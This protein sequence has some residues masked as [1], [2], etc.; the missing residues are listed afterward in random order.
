M[1]IHGPWTYLPG[2]P[3]T[4]KKEHAHIPPI[5]RPA[6]D[7]LPQLVEVEFLTSGTSRDR[8]RRGVGTWKRGTTRATSPGSMAT[9][10]KWTGDRA[11][12]KP[13]FQRPV[14][15]CWYMHRTH[16]SFGS[17][18]CG[19]SRLS[20]FRHVL[21][22]I[23]SSV[24]VGVLRLAVVMAEDLR[25]IRRSLLEGLNLTCSMILDDWVAWMILNVLIPPFRK[26]QL[27]PQSDPD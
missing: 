13:P 24:K 6:A 20:Q 16:I 14:G 22:A 19:K 18:V 1:I 8:F 25:S 17:A 27:V 23:F 3:W 15:R 26:R 4:R 12:P 2:R 9:S 11:L 10:N 21:L 5:P 7:G